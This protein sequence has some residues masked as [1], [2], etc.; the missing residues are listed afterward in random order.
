M[1]IYRTF[2]MA[3]RMM[4]L[5]VDEKHV[6]VITGRP[7]TQDEIDTDDYSAQYIPKEEFI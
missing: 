5:V 3:G 1:A 4:T 2:V 7:A 6:H